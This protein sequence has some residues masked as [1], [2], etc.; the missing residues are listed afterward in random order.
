[1]PIK[2]ASQK[3][4]AEHVFG[5]RRTTAKRFRAGLYA[6]LSSNDQQ[7]HSSGEFDGKL[8]SSF[9]DCRQAVSEIS[10]DAVAPLRLGERRIAGTAVISEPFCLLPPNDFFAL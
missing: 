3:A 8:S 10:V 5:H 7:T 1:M 4:K 2:R 9:P 6:R